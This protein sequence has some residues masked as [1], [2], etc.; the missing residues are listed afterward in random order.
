MKDIVSGN[1]IFITPL[2]ITVIL[3]FTVIHSSHTIRTN[4][5]LLRN[6]NLRINELKRSQHDLTLTFESFYHNGENLY[7]QA[8]TVLNMNSPY[9]NE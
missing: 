1:M 6:H 8:S 9:F 2:L 5:T 7:A 4:E 3:S